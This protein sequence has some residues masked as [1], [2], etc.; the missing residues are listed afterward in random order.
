MADYDGSS[1]LGIS[2]HATHVAGTL[3]A[4]GKNAAARGMAPAALVDA[5]DWTSDLGEMGLAGLMISNHSYSYQ[6]GWGT[7]AVQ[8]VATPAWFGNTEIS[9]TED[10][11]FGF[12]R[13][14]AVE[15]DRIVYNA[16][17]Y[18]P[19]W[20]VGNE[21]GS[22]GEA[23]VGH[24][25]GHYA[26]NGS[27][28]IWT[29]GVSRPDDGDANGY[30]TIPE[31]GVAKNILTVGAVADIP[32][33]YQSAEDVRVSAFS[34]FGP[35][36]DGRIKPDLVANGEGVLSTFSGS[37]DD[38]AELPGTSV[39]SPNVAGSL[40]LLLERH[41]RDASSPMW[42]STLRGLAIHTADEAGDASGPDYQHGW[43]LLNAARAAELQ[44][45][46]FESGTLAHVK[47]VTL[48]DGDFIEFPVESDG[49]EALRVT[50]CWNDPPGIPVPDAVDPLAPMLVN[51]LDLRV[52][53]GVE[54]FEPWMLDLMAPYEPAV[55]GDN[56]RDNV[57]QIVING[58]EAGEYLVRVT[59]KGALVDAEGTPS[60][61]N[62]TVLV[63]GN[64]A[65]A[66]FSPEIV[67]VATTAEDEVSL[68]W[69]A[70]VGRSYRVQRTHDIGLG[71]WTD[72][73][74]AIQATKYQVAAAVPALPEVGAGFFRVVENGED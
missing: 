18:L 54:V 23:P 12:Y 21:R 17:T 19:V 69:Q 70:V 26:Y 30:D 2:D 36:D 64:V 68:L 56:T 29:T 53:R 74:G 8:G 58:P 22:P 32:G 62:V 67:E 1:A 16:Q 52:R 10:F 46:N 33:G 44:G 25:S 3:A 45:A 63:S 31:N 65:P 48:P 72:V 4:A 50:I 51:D 11:R 57:E 13:Q 42:S 73:G 47:E 60:F 28:L 49:V 20:A 61:Q 40:A 41:F 27:S 5:Y 55:T 37:N 43:G 15:I 14:V 35:T 24:E 6:T 66:E 38:Y 39:A 9:Q 34:S 71:V 7:V 59:H